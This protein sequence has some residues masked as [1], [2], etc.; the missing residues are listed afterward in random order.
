MTM[1]LDQEGAVIH[2]FHKQVWHLGHQSGGRC[3]NKEDS[4]LFQFCSHKRW[5]PV[6]EIFI[7]DLLV[8]KWLINK[9]KKRKIK[10][11]SVL[12]WWQWW[13][14][15]WKVFLAWGNRNKELKLSRVSLS[16]EFNLISS[17]AFYSAKKN[18]LVKLNSFLK[19]VAKVKQ[20][21]FFIFLS[22]Q[23]FLCFSVIPAP[24]N[25]L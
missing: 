3:S 6:C 25:H 16:K 19:I 9:R 24:T 15:Y 14:K 17:I 1:P 13:G 10:E 18:P 5:Y 2:V 22:W 7:D 20:G 11:D 8:Q 4:L 23:Q 12:P 21:S